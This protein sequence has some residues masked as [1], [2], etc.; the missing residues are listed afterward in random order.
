MSPQQ[1]PGHPLPPPPHQLAEARA[2]FARGDWD[3]ARRTMERAAE[4]FPLS[5]DDQEILARSAWWLGDVQ[6]SMA[7]SEDV[8][9]GLVAGKQLQAAAKSALTLSLQWGVR[10][11]IAVSSA[12]LNRARRLLDSLPESPEHGYLLYLEGNDAIYLEGDADSA[13]AASVQLTAMNS[14]QKAPE[15]G[16]FALMLSGLA[17]VRNGQARR[18]FEDLDQALLPVMAG[19]VSAEWGGDIYCSVIHLCYELADYSRMRAWTDAL[20]AWCAGLSTS[21]MYSGIV[22]V[23][24]L[25]LISAEGGWKQAEEELAHLGGRLRHAH[26]WIAADCFCEL[27]DIRRRQGNRSGAATAYAM[28][29]A[30]GSD[31]QPGS[32]LLLADAG[33]HDEALTDLRAALADRGRLGRAWLLLPIVELLAPRDTQGAEV[34]CCELEGTAA[35]YGTAGLLAW[36][37]HARGAVLMAQGHWIQSLPEFEAAA[38]GYR[39]QHLRYELARIHERMSSVRAA[40]GESGAAEAERSTAAAIRTQLGAAPFSM[41]ALDRGPD[42]LTAREREVLGCV[43][44]GSSNREIAQTLTISEKTAGRHLANIF[45]KIGVSSRTAAAAWARHHGISERPRA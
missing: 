13:L 26:A 41:P 29:R 42:G 36:A 4:E 19:H 11:N 24:E 14:R 9:R 34:Y 43:L 28:A 22:R 40:L 2:A 6:G 1:L 12:W 25:Q 3:A 5:L 10:G 37:H 15:L 45:T 8:F 27:G 33:G 7:L 20:A 38:Q 30:L 17:A 23:H 16:S 32:A 31:A 21:F 35:Y 39:S 44:S 18:G